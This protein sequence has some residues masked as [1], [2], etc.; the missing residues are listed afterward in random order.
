M[1]ENE[2]SAKEYSLYIETLLR[3]VNPSMF[4][5]SDAIM[6]E[7]YNKIV[8]AVQY[9][10]SQRK[11]DEFRLYYEGISDRKLQ[12]LI[13]E[14]YDLNQMLKDLHRLIENN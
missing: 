7:P 11:F 10:V 9:R 5:A 6:L 1:I 3:K 4:G 12:D 14:Q 13:D 2:L 8:E